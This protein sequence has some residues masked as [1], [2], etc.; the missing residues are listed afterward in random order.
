MTIIGLVRIDL[1]LQSAG[2]VSAPEL[3]TAV[4]LPLSRR[5]GDG[6]SDDEVW[7]PPTSLAGSLRA[8]AS[9]QAERW[10]GSPADRRAS[11]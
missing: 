8:H 6:Q 9:E 10:F 3:R 4:D 5:R 1:V 11:R 7:T 2:G